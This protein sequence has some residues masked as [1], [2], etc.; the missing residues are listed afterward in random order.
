MALV[1]DNISE[2]DLQRRLY[3]DCRSGSALLVPNYTPGGWWECDIFRVTRAGYFYEYEIKLSVADFRNDAKKSRT[4]Y[5]QEFGEPPEVERKYERLAAKDLNGPACFYY[6]VPK[7]IE[8]TV[9]KELPP[10]AGLMVMQRPGSYIKTVEKAPL[11]HDKKI[12]EHKC[13]HAQSVCVWRYWDKI[14]AR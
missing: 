14:N 13:H 4:I 10:F 12:E 1:T 2:R 7:E 5:P 9:R 11:L 3:F 8:E 6:V